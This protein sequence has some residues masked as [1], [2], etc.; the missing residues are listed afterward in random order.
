MAPELPRQRQ[1][2]PQYEA[3][4]HYILGSSLGH[5]ARPYF[6]ER[7]RK[8]TEELEEEE[9]E[10]KWRR[11]RITAPSGSGYVGQSSPKIPRVVFI[12]QLYFW[13]NQPRNGNRLAQDKSGLK[14]RS[15]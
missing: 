7:R 13:R 6:K 1:G 11:P 9:E 8:E 3:S 2:D 12:W 15:L 5:T 10:E 14:V 4:R